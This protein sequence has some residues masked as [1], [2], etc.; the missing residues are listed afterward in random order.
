MLSRLADVSA[1]RPPSPNAQPRERSR[2]VAGGSHYRGGAVCLGLLLAAGCATARNYEDPKGPVRVGVGAPPPSPRAEL[3]V[4]SFNIKFATHVDR[5]VALLSRPGPL[6]DADVLVLQEMDEA[7]TEEVARALGLNHVY[8]PSAVHPSSHRDFGVAILSPWSLEDPRKVP[9]PHEHRFRHLRRA[10]AA[11]TAITALGP[12]RV[13]GVHLE[14]PSGLWGG[15]RRD[16]ARAVLADASTWAGPVVVAGDFNGRGG[17][18]ETA[19]AGFL[20]LTERVGPTAF[21]FAFDHVLAR[22][23]CPAGEGAAGV[24]KDATDA[25][26]HDPVWAVL[27]PCPPA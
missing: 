1:Y 6:R 2:G 20:W 27:R 16:Q 10:A 7:S 22:G 18:Q 21:L 8:V 25:S 3:R 5:A 11:V 26:D 12:V 19:K 24:S 17:A 23:L 9:L 13:Y 15:D 14:S 4:V